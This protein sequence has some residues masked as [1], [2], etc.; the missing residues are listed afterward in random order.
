[1]VVVVVVVVAALSVEA[2]GRRVVVV[3]G[4]DEEEDDMGPRRVA[5]RAGAYRVRQE[6]G[7]EEVVILVLPITP[8]SRPGARA[9]C[10]AAL[11]AVG[12]SGADGW[13][14]GLAPGSSFSGLGGSNGPG[15]GDDAQAFS[16]RGFAVRGCVGLSVQ[17][18]E[19]GVCGQRRR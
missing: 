17:R 11:L 14:R 3:D 13:A 19:R 16:T 6:E 7:E 2:V 10:M 4:D 12:R 9:S 5:R 15:R 18:E 1:V 8:P